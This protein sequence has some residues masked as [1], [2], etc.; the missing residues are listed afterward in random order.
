MIKA[1]YERKL[2]WTDGSRGLRVHH[3]RA[4]AGEQKQ[5]RANISIHKQERGRESDRERM[6]LHTSKSRRSASEEVRTFHSES[7]HI[8]QWQGETPKH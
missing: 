6:H 2:N 3:G 5:L 1:M 8:G 7:S 4:K